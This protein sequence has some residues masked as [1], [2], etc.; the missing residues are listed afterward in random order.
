MIKIFRFKSI[1][2]FSSKYNFVLCLSV[3][4][5]LFLEIQSNLLKDS[6]SNKIF[7]GNSKIFISLNQILQYF[8]HIHCRPQIKYFRLLNL[9]Q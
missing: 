3:S 4:E 5:I 6:F 7:F 9:A 2:F 8:S 1:S